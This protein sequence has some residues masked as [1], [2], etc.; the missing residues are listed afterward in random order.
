LVKNIS[1]EQQLNNKKRKASK[2]GS[3]AEKNYPDKSKQTIA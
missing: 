1:S 3:N 2:I